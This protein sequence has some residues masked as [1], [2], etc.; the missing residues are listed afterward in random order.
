M[1]SK[2]LRILV[3]D[4]SNMFRRNFEANPAVSQNGHV[5][6]LVGTLNSIQKVCKELDPDKICLIWDGAGGSHRKRKINPG[7]KKG[8]KPA[9]RLNRFARGQLT[10][11][12]HMANHLWQQTR[13]LEY[14]DKM[15][16]HQIMI[17]NVEADDVIS[18]VVQM[19]DFADWQ[20][21]IYSSDKDFYQLA[22]GSLGDIDTLIYRPQTGGRADLV[23][24]DT[25]IEESGIH[26]CN[27]AVARA[28]AGDK[29]DNLPGAPGVGLG[30]IA[31]RFSYLSEEKDYNLQHIFE[32]CE[33]NLGKLKIYDSIIDNRNLIL[34]NYGMMQLDAPN[35]P[36]SSTKII[37]ETIREMDMS[38]DKTSV[39]I[40]KRQDD[41]ATARHEELYTRMKRYSMVDKVKT[42]TQADLAN[43]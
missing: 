15:P 24:Q 39:E 43:D 2:K 41:I 9:G 8:R 26:P 11:E 32:E 40:M 10:T 31:K 17:D 27:F 5:G 16:I 36:Y 7:Y 19:T 21:V 6:G 30:K 3:I 25:I 38:F 37:K 42:S 12:Q 18:Y 23:H 29:S 34:T 28:I 33:K 4:G 22:K 35:I 1:S 13:L 20:K 14:I